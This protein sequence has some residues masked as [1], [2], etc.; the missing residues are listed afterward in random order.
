MISVM[1][2]ACRNCMVI[3]IVFFTFTRFAAGQTAGNEPQVKLIKQW[4]EPVLT[5]RSP[6]AENIRIGFEGGRVIKIKGTYHMFTSEMVDMPPWVKMKLGYW[7]SRDG[8]TWQRKATIRE[9]SGDY[10]GKDPRAALWSPLPVYD[11]SEN[12]WNLFYVAYKA[13]PSTETRFLENH[14]GRIW[15]AISATPGIEGIGGPYT[16]IKVILEPGPDCG[17]WEG[18][19]GTDSFFPWKVGNTWY[20]FHGSAKTDSLP[21]KHWLVGMASS[22]TTSIAGPWKRIPALSPAPMED[23]FIENPIVTP[24]PEGGWM[25]VYDSF[26]PDAIGWAFSADGIHWEKG[27][28]LVIQPSAGEWSKDI[29]TPLGLVHEEGNRYTLFYT[30]FEV[31]PDWALMQ[32]GNTDMTC[33]IGRVELEIIPPDFSLRVL[34]T[35]VNLHPQVADNDRDGINDIIAVSRKVSSNL[36][37]ESEILESH[38]KSSCGTHGHKNR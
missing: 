17:A 12:R 14:E 30:G 16:D 34:D 21:V 9:S 23:H 29:R 10:T 11:E 33:A 4:K 26:E 25:C 22:T 28:A 7:V 31:T 27:H 32:K 1:T 13:A 37:D 20:A 36:S 19:Q 38:K 6:G 35:T 2:L 15:R 8:L 24:L 18:L 5:T 3:A